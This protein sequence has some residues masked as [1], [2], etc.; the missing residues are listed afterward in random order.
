MDKADILIAGAALNG[1]AAAVALAGP[2]A[3]RPLDIL[4]L[5]QADPTKYARDT[6]DGRASAITASSRRMLDALG[7]WEAILP[8]AQPMRDI[9]ITDSKLGATAR[10]A[11]LHFGEE[12]HGGEPSA[13]MVENRHL[14]GALLD[15]ALASPTVRFRT[16]TRIASYSFGPG[17]VSIGTEAGDIAK[18]SLLIAAD[19][20]ASPARKAAGIATS[21][22]SYD[23]TGIVTTVAHERPHNGRAEEHFLPSGP[24]A[25]LPLPNNRSSLVWTERSD[26]ARRIIAL[27]DQAF[28]AELS[29]RFGGHLGEIEVVGPRHAYPLSMQIAQSFTAERLALIGD[30][31]H[32][33]HPIAG[34]GFNLGLR[35]VAALAESIAEAVKL[36]L[37]PGSASVLETYARWRRF[38][39]V[40]TA[41][42][43]D[44]LTRLFSN[45]NPALRALRG[46]GLR[47][48]GS[49]GA[50]KG[51]FMREA[52]GET[53]H[54]PKLLRGEAV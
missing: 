47:A 50:L 35:D 24:F 46:V 29:R 28:L 25:I 23:Q 19:G 53:G 27:D 6:F 30:A 1:L 18:A 7:V 3:L 39:T 13:H 20:R 34:L 8:H 44:G 52:A 16:D 32:V 2:K 22:W 37:D 15:A 5:D 17:F 38:D 42:A 40:I 54:V 9:I 48:A 11:L 21:G 10:P 43:T 12:D 51:F 26:D 33:V 36:G 49:V 45:D 4:I 14:Y 41:M 31:A